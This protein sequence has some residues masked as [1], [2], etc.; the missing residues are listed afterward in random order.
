MHRTVAAGHGDEVV[1]RVGDRQIVRVAVEHARQID[2]IHRVVDDGVAVEY[3]QSHAGRVGVAFHDAYAVKPRRECAGAACKG[4][5]ARCNRH[6]CIT[7]LCPYQR[8]EL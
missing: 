3:P 7:I 5:S 6:S 4:M 2:I 1:H 8:G